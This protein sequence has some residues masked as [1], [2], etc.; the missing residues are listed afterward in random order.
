MNTLPNNLK[1]DVRTKV[2]TFR[3]RTGNM[4]LT[5]F[6]GKNSLLKASGRMRFRTRDKR[7]LDAKHQLPEVQ[8]TIELLIFYN[9]TYKLKYHKENPPIKSYLANTYNMLSPHKNHIGSLHQAVFLYLH[10]PKAAYPE[11]YSTVCIETFKNL[12]T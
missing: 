3:R 2:N 5:L 4:N 8:A 6:N 10:N 11:N 7:V 1:F 12:I 9:P